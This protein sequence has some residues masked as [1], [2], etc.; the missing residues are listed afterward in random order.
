MA[1]R[2]EDVQAAD[3]RDARPEFDVRA[4]ARHVR[5]DGDGP[6]LSRP[7]DDFSLLLVIFGVEDGMDQPFLLQHPREHFARLDT[8]GA[9]EDR[10]S[11]L[12]ERLDFGGD[13][14]EFF[15]PGFID[16]I[17]PVFA[18]VRLVRRDRQHAEL[19]DVQEFRRL[20]LRRAGHAREFLVKAEIIL[21]RDRRERLRFTFDGH[22]FLGF[23]GLMQAI[24]PAAAGHEPAGVLVHDHH[25]VV[26]HDI[27]HVEL[28]KAV[29]LEQLRDRMDLLRLGLELRLQLRLG[30]KPLAR[31]GFR[32][33]I[34]V[35]QQRVQ[36]RQH[37]RFWVLRTDEVAALLGQVGLVAFFIRGKKQFLLLAVKINLLLV[38]VQFQFG[39]VHQPEIFRVF[40]NFHQGFRLGL[41][42]L[43]AEKQH[44]DLAFQR[45]G[46]LDVRA[47]G[48][49]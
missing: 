39:L 45:G 44:P 48:R 41:A 8:D 40:Q 15:A 38:L 46:I 28:V 3:F 36:V 11:L 30:L 4:E 13:S 12:V 5:G 14:G 10:T 43:D 17:V 7:R 19:V 37:E 16:G 35:V 21:D 6:A 27:F 32:A 47:V 24:A 22:A 23:H 34:H 9:D 29:S 49:V 2:A 42:G 20:G 1:F 31:V 33:G 26:L 25:F 18:D